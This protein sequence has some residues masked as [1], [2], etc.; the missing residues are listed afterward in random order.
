MQPDWVDFFFTSVSDGAVDVPVAAGVDV[1][2][3]R[4]TVAFDILVFDI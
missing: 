1:R 2:T 4:A 3:I